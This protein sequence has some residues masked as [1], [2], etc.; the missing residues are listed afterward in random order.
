MALPESFAKTAGHTHARMALPKSFAMVDSPRYVGSAAANSPTIEALNS[1][2][3]MTAYPS[4][5]QW[6]LATIV[7]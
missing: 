4:P 2:H 3:S 5:P 7:R 1:N 6:N